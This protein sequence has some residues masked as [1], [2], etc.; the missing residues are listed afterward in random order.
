VISFGF[1]LRAKSSGL[2]IAWCE[3][4]TF[5]GRPRWN[6][7]AVQ[8]IEQSFHMVYK[9]YALRKLPGKPSVRNIEHKFTIA[10]DEFGFFHW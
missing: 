9:Q 7:L 2:T 6:E 5:G 10:Y 1:V 3:E 4:V 8:H